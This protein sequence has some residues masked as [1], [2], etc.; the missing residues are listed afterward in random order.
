MRADALADGGAFGERPR[1]RSLCLADVAEG[2]RAQRSQS[3]AGKTGP[4]QERAAIE[5]AGLSGQGL[6]D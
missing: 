4:A 1:G 2:Q 3:P 6:R 5:P